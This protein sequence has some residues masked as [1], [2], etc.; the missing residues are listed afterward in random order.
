LNIG[1]FHQFPTP[2]EHG[3]LHLQGVHEEH[4]PTLQVSPHYLIN[5]Q[6]EKERRRGSEERK[7]K[8]RERKCE[9]LSGPLW[10]NCFKRC[11]YLDIT[12]SIIEYLVVGV[13]TAKQLV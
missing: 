7:G 11:A 6:E 8:G 12:Y 10:N 1:Y 3:R 5:Y 2:V 4:F 13:I 9:W